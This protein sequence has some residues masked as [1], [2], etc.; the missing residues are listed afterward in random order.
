MNAGLGDAAV[1]SQGNHFELHEAT[2]LWQI[3]YLYKIGFCNPEDIEIEK[4]RDLLNV[5][6]PIAHYISPLSDDLEGSQVAN[7][8]TKAEKFHTLV[9]G[10][11]PIPMAVKFFIF[12]TFVGIFYCIFTITRVSYQFYKYGSNK[13]VVVA[14]VIILAG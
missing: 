7:D 12:I 11:L 6:D 10:F 13:G 2:A 14:F 8:N 9:M 5:W 3:E 1:K 4:I